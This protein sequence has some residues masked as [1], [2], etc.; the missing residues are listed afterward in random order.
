MKDMTIKISRQTSQCSFHYT[1]SV[2]MPLTIH[3]ANPHSFLVHS[4]TIPMDWKLEK[5]KNSNATGDMEHKSFRYKQATEYP[6]T[7]T[8]TEQGPR[9]RSFPALLDLQVLVRHTIKMPHAGNLASGPRA[10]QSSPTLQSK[11][12]CHLTVQC[13]LLHYLPYLRGLLQR[14]TNGNWKHNLE[15]IEC[16][17]KYTILL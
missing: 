14:R 3:M 2:S 12:I 13:Q 17:L 9:R 15:S 11:W 16:I 4:L 7:H 8:H 5:K 6:A 1:H 10:L